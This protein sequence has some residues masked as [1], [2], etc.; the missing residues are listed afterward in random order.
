MIP[1]YMNKKLIL[2]FLKNIYSK[3]EIKLGKYIHYNK[4]I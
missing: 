4:I 1:I 3:K 2:I